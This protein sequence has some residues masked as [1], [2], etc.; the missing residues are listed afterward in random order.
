M[1]CELARL[2]RDAVVEASAEAEVPV[3]PV[4]PLNAL[5]ES[6]TTMYGTLPEAFS[7]ASGTMR[8]SPAGSPGPVCQEG[9]VK[10][11]LAPPPVPM[12]P[13]PPAS[14]LSFH[15]RSGIGPSTDRFVSA[16]FVASQ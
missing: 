2:A 16:S 4:K 14:A 13:R 9:R 5:L 8:R 12:S 6:S 7:A 1:R 3:T 15:T 11:T 10:S